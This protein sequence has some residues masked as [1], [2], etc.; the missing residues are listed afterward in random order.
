MANRILTAENW[1]Q[2]VRDKMGTDSAY[3]PDSAI[4]QPDIITVAEA[5]IISQIPD[6][7]TLENDA[8]VY[9]ESAVVLECCVLLSPSMS[10][11]IPKKETGPHAG[12]ELNTDWT[13]KKAEFEAERDS[14]IGKLFD[15]AFPE[16]ASSSLF[17][18]RVTYPK[19]SW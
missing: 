7:T 1:Q 5:N 2:R 11:R 14:N 19:R 10:A 17:G 16:L 12:H 15:I 4:E 3:L 8:K 13:A 18:F 9:L 6:Y